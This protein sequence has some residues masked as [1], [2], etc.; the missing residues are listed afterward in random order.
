M[1][2][3]AYETICPPPAAPSIGSRRRWCSSAPAQF[4]PPDPGTAPSSSIRSLPAL[5]TGF[6]CRL[7]SS[8]RVQSF[9]QIRRRTSSCGCSSNNGADLSRPRLHRPHAPRHPGDEGPRP[10]SPNS[11][12]PLPG[13]PIFG[14]TSFSILPDLISGR[15]GERSVQPVGS[16]AKGGFPCGDDGQCLQLQ[17][18]HGAPQGRLLP[19]TLC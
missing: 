18:V 13:I 19:A 5:S 11:T 17:G 1:L 15:D 7:S 3:L 16:A 8:A 4:H 10:R 12:C 9:Y 2:I 14:S 6:Y